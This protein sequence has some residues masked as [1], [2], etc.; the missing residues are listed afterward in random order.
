MLSKSHRILT[1]GERLGDHYLMLAFI[2]AALGFILGRSHQKTPRRD[3][4][5]LGAWAAITEP[6]VKYRVKL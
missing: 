6:V 1:Q 5:Q 2:T 4:D 3:D